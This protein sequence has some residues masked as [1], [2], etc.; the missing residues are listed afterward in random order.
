MDVST[1]V[2]SIIAGRRTAAEAAAREKYIAARENA[3]FKKADDKLK[4]LSFKVERERAKGELSAALAEE[5]RRLEAERETTLKALGLSS[6]DFEPKYFCPLCRDTG[7]L[8]GGACDCFK[9]LYIKKVKE[10][11]NLGV[12]ASYRFS[13]CNLALVKDETH[14]KQLKQLFTA[15]KNY[16]EK[17][18]QNKY[19]NIL[20]LG[21]VGV[22]KS[23][24][25]SAV[26]NA[27][28][29]RGYFVKYLSAFEL[30]QTLVTFHTST[31]E[32]K[33]G[34]MEQLFDYDLLAID[35]LG[36][37]P[38]FRNVT[39]EYLHLILSERLAAGKSTFITS[40][41]TPEEILDRYGE[42]IFSRIFDKK[43]TLVKYILGSDLRL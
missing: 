10:I 38:I 15:F 31:N 43:S 12:S 36:T 22:G 30:N 42:R 32:A 1:K 25:L 27:V 2:Q 18:P 3:A 6:A 39:R 9:S 5:E 19:R 17:F 11:C 24:L 37:E 40:N 4:Q 33:A 7:S 16:A 35:D 14:K 28:L 29:D 8:D 20:L 21:S 34:L 13:D 26:A 41:L 23:F